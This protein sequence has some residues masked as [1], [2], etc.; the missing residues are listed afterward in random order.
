ML[1]RRWIVLL[2]H[3][4]V[5][6]KTIT[7]MSVCTKKS[8]RLLKNQIYSIDEEEQRQNEFYMDTTNW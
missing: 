5:Q 4:L 1:Y 7:T 3:P 6:T 2:F 8:D